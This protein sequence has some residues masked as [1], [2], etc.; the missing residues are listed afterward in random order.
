MSFIW[1]TIRKVFGLSPPPVGDVGASPE[2]DRRAAPLRH[3]AETDMDEFE[4]AM[5]RQMD[6]DAESVEGSLAATA[7]GAPSQ[8]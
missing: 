1:N 4:D 8:L 5:V 7:R 2:F 3:Y 6:F